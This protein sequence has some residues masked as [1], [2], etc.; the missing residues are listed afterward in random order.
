V[1]IPAVYQVA[2]DFVRHDHDTVP[3]TDFSQ[4]FQFLPFPDHSP[5]IVGTAEDQHRGVLIYYGFQ[6]IQIEVK[7]SF[8][9]SQRI[10]RN[11]PSGTPDTFVEWEIDGGLHNDLVS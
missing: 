8:M 6:V 11:F 2:V 1:A 5:G 10:Q 9:Q 3:V 4:G 7:P